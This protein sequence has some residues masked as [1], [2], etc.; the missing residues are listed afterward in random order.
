MRFYCTEVEQSEN[1]IS[2]LSRKDAPIV[3]LL[4]INLPQFFYMLS[5]V[6]SLGC[7]SILKEIV[8]FRHAFLLH[9][10]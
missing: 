7:V 1:G 2:N 5:R 4:K 10:S 9:R 6:L 8:G 3:G